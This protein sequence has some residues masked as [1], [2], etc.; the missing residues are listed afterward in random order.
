MVGFVRL[1]YDWDFPGALLAMERALQ[2]S[3]SDP[4]VLVS[5]AWYLLWVEGKS[6]ESLAVSERLL[7]VAPLDLAL[8]AERVRLLFNAR[9]YQR[10]LEEVERVRELDPDF[11]DLLI[12]SIYTEL[13]RLEEA[14]RAYVAF[15]E[16]CGAP[17]D[18]AREAQERGWAEGGWEGAMRAWIE[19]GTDKEGYSPGLIAI[20]YTRIGETDEAFAWLERAY[21]EREP[22]MVALRT[23]PSFDPLRSDPRFDDLLRRIGFP[24]S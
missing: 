21:R 12:G 20:N 23:Y 1:L 6:E 7:R 10:A 5:Y 14:H 11:V 9:Q 16:R 22:L 24:E 4:G 15:F 19:A 8:R 18:S 17:C 3:P 2:L 13:G